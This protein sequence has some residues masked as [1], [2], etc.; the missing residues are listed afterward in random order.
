M[1]HVA[2]LDADGRGRAGVADRRRVHQCQCCAPC[3]LG[4]GGSAAVIRG[5]QHYA[6]CDGEDRG[7]AVSGTG[8]CPAPRQAGGWS[9]AGPRTA[10]LIDAG[11]NVAD[12]GLMARITINL[13]DGLERELTEAAREQGKTEADLI[14]EAI[15]R[16]LRFR[17][18]T[19]AVPIPFF[20]RRVGPLAEP[21]KPS[22][23]SDVALAPSH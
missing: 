7:R 17:R 5:R 12:R 4:A 21:A 11:T 14:L 15:E 23:G 13:P 20:A 9:A 22:A 16:L 3:P 18:A 2:T 8:A 10:D 1:S 19:A 6:N